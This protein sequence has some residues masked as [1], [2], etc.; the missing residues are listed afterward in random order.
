MVRVVNCHAGV[1]GL[2]PGGPKDFPLGI[3]SSMIL[4]PKVI[5][6]SFVCTATYRLLHF[7]F[8]NKEV[9]LHTHQQFGEKIQDLC[10]QGIF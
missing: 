3:T 1:L 7:R 6:Q 10:V 5:T 2:N 8:S 4:T 9:P